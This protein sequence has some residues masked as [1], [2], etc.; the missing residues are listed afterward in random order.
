MKIQLIILCIL[1]VISDLIAS[2]GSASYQKLGMDARGIA[3]GRT[4]SCI[5]NGAS[6]LFWNPANLCIHSSSSQEKFDL[7]FSLMKYPNFD[8][9]YLTSAVAFR[10]DKFGAGIGYIQYGVENIPQYDNDMNYLGNFHDVERSLLLGFAFKVPYIMKVGVA[11]QG[12]TQGFNYENTLK[13]EFEYS[14]GVRA[15]IIL[16][17]IYKYDRLLLSVVFNNRSFGSKDEMRPTT[18]AGCSWSSN[19]SKRLYLKNIHV[20]T[21]IEQ[22]KTFP[23]KLKFGSEIFVADIDNFKLFIRVGIDDIIIETRSTLI[24]KDA[25]KYI[26]LNELIRLNKKSTCGF[27]LEMPPIKIIDKNIHVRFDYAFVN[28]AYRALNFITVGYYW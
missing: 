11:L 17:P 4:A 27:G 2:V 21:E 9:E 28:E 13:S 18:T 24:R 3:M 1:L 25:K 26:N 8:I 10:R 5:S 22:Q 7:M 19:E 15:G 6:A 23:I 14:L 20:I 16:F 12:L